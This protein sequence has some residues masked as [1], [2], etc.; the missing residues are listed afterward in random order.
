MPKQTFADK[1]KSLFHLHGETNS[2]FFE[3][4]TDALI[5]GDMGVKTAGE[6][7][8][9]LEKNCRQNHI[10]GEAETV[11]ALRD[12]LV[13]TLRAGTLAP[14]LPGDTAIY[15]VLG[16]NGVGKTTTIAKLA[17]LYQ[18]QGL[19]MVIAAADTFRA[20]A[21]E[22]LK[23]HGERLGVRVVAQQHGS[24]PA[25]VVFDA[26]QAAAAQGGGLVL[27]DTAGRLHNK[28][29]LMR[30][31]QKI[32]RIGLSKASPGCYKKIL[33]LDSTTGQN[34]FRQ[35]EVFHQAVG[36]DLIVMTK[37][38][39]TAKGGAVFSISRELGI[40]IGYLCFGERYGDIRPFDALQ[41]TGEFLGIQG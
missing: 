38:D 22:Q 13:Q 17:G 18:K 36:I 33:V 28:E 41:Y 6:I 7:M 21:I 20:A 15:L 16:V 14:P 1:L 8:D 12:L 11:A 2:A 23:I 5:Q 25:A 37:Y 30:E 19:P 39:S 10:S 34:A 31:L 9:V 27:A 35:A 26:A 4:L 29:N 3:D 24:D 32:D 40:P